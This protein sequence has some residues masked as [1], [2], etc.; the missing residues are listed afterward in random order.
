MLDYKNIRGAAG[1]AWPVKEFDKNAPKP[2]FNWQGPEK[3]W[4]AE[5]AEKGWITGK[6]PSQIKRG[7]LMVLY[8]QAI[9]RTKVAFVR[10]VFNSTVVFEFVDPPYSRV[11]TA[12]LTMDQLLEGGALGGYL[13][14]SVILPERKKR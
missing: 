9:K 11:V 2:G 7:S 10:D 12:R 4:A 5:A 3:E 8:N 1:S 6:K 13:F 14:D